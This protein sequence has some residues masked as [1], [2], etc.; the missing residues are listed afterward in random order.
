MHLIIGNKSATFPD[1]L[2]NMLP[3]KR[4]RSKYSF[5]T[6]MYSNISLSCFKGN[7]YCNI[8]KETSKYFMQ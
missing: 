5:C 2:T 3:M 6:F 4:W 8:T 7:Y 1:H